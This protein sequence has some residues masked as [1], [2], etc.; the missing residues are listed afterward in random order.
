MNF[1]LF[2]RAGLLLAG[3][4]LYLA[5]MFCEGIHTQIYAFVSVERLVDVTSYVTVIWSPGEN[6]DGVIVGV[7]ETCAVTR[8][9][10]SVKKT[11]R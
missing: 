6:I 7:N 2:V 9:A 8:P 4:T 3:F 5:S 11:A 1:A 10:V